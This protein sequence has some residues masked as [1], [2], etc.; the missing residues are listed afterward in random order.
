MLEGGARG[1]PACGSWFGTISGVR[2]LSED[3]MQS[4]NGERGPWMF[5]GVVGFR[6][7]WGPTESTHRD[8]H[9]SARARG[10]RSK[11]GK[12]AR[13]GLNHLAPLPAS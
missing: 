8:S 10:R 4:A 3:L 12:N 2:N 1:S 13:L 6:R 9:P 7:P 11:V 5:Q